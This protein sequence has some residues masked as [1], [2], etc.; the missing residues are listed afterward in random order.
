MFGKYNSQVLISD[1]SNLV[2]AKF[3]IFKLGNLD[4][5]FYRGTKG[6]LA[7]G[8]LKFTLFKQK[9]SLLK[10]TTTEIASTQI[11]VKGVLNTKKIKFT[12]PTWKLLDEELQSDI[13]NQMQFIIQQKNL[14]KGIDD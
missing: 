6:E 5:Y 9:R 11:P 14:N 12:I 13:Y 4:H 10:T 8:I 2:F 1:A 3:G 7:N